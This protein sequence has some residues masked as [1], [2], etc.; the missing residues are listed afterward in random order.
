MN[1]HQ[2]HAIGSMIAI[3]LAGA[4]QS[5]QPGAFLRMH[6][7]SDLLV[8]L[9]ELRARNIQRLSRKNLQRAFAVLHRHVVKVSETFKAKEI[10]ILL[11]ASK[12]LH[13]KINTLMAHDLKMTLCA[14]YVDWC[15]AEQVL[16]NTLT[17]QDFY[18]GELSESD[19]DSCARLLC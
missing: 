3:Q 1:T 13:C 18:G 19:T 7:S 12:R 15:K 11:E 14:W 17:S 6:T 8:G 2:Q 4:M 10:G 5:R 16:N 9:V